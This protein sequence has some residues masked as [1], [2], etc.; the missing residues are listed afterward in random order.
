MASEEELKQARLIAAGR[1]ATV[2][3]HRSLAAWNSVHTF[4][5][6]GQLGLPAAK[7]RAA[8]QHQQTMREVATEAEY[9]K[10][11]TVDRS[12]LAERGFFD[13]VAVQMTELAANTFESSLDAASLI[14]AHSVL[15]NSVLEWL[16]I[17][18]L[19]APDDV[20]HLV[21]QRRFSLAEM[22]DAGF[23]ELRS[24]A[25]GA[26]LE[27]LERESLLKKLDAIMSVCK[28]GEGVRAPLRYRYDRKRIEAL[29]NLRHN[30]VH[31]DPAIMR[32]PEGDDDIAYLR[33][34]DMFMLS[35]VNWRFDVRIDPTMLDIPAPEA[36]P[37]K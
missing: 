22:R 34:T 12:V 29:D 32:L 19:A 37:L 6:M 14:F 25:I 16:R 3:F 17:C 8:W 28:P 4:R 1:S 9:A 13:E 11:F 7:K 27:Q 36:A 18:W 20:L 21:E 5:W 35:L 10:I 31:G 24:S 33:Q 23:A 30:Y 2:Q 26:Y 15:D